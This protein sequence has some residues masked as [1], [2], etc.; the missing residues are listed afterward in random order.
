MKEIRKSNEAEMILEFLK[1]EISS[2][3]F[4]K[5]ICDALSS[6]N[7]DE[8]IINN[9]DITNEQENFQRLKVMKL[10]RGYPDD[11]L[12]ENFPQINEWK[13][14]E[15]NES[16]I[17]SIYYIDYDYWNELSNG[18]SKPV[19]AAKNIQ[20]GKEIYEV[21]NQPFLDGVEYSENNTFPP[22]ILIT[23]NEEKY[24]IIE[25]HSRMTVYGFD[26]SK[27]NGTFAYVGYTSEEEM[28]KYDPRM[29]SI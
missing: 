22:V 5:D 17:D 7:L 9:G 25:G 24:L 4:H 1:G 19:E 11:E 28:K 20:S 2:K 29:L 3:R 12:F 14:M 23:C 26:P 8:V 16:D 6:M 18:T 21:S 10:F 27:L 15:L 13:L